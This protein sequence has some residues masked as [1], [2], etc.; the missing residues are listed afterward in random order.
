MLDSYYSLLG[1]DTATGI[2]T[3]E[4]MEELGLPSEA[5]RLHGEGPYPEWTGP[6]LWPQGSYPRGGQRA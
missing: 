2:P 3:R 5:A 1:Q 4:R 6:R